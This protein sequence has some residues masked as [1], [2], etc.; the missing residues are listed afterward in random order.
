MPPVAVLSQSHIFGLNGNVKNNVIFINENVVIYP[1]AN[2]VVVFNSETKIQKFIPIS[3]DSDSISALAITPNKKI[4]AVAERGEKG[5]SISIWDLQR[6]HKK[7]VFTLPDD[8]PDSFACLA[9]SPDCKYLMAQGG[10][11][12]WTLAIWVWEKSKLVSAFLLHL[13]IVE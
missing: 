2:F 13:H 11:P 7:K 12:E 9:F 6:M 3:D 5:P 10:A 8:T 1:A 4:L